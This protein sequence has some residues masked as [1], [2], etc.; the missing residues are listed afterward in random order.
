V[1]NLRFLAY[2]INRYSILANYR[3][4]VKSSAEKCFRHVVVFQLR[5]LVE[6]NNE[7]IINRRRRLS[8]EC[9]LI[10]N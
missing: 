1:S 3:Q 7:Q 10:F 5:F 2:S 4:S 6:L 8:E 9:I